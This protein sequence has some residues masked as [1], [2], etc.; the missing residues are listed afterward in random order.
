MSFASPNFTRYPPPGKSWLHVIAQLPVKE[1]DAVI[2]RLSEVEVAS[3]LRESWEFV[4][5]REQLP[6]PGLWTV[7]LLL[8]GRGFGK[9]RTGSEWIYEQHRTGAVKSQSGIIAATHNDLLRYCLRGPSGLITLT[10]D[11]PFRPR[12]YPSDLMLVWPDETVTLL[13]SSEKPDRIR[14]PN[15]EKIWGD[16]FASWAYMEECWD[17]IEFA[18]RESD[19]PRA[20]LTTTPKPR[21]LLRA[22]MQDP[23]TI[24]TGGRQTDNAENLSVRYLSRMRRRYAGTRQGRQELNAEL[25]DEA[26]GA[27]WKREWIDTTRV[28]TKPQDI[29]CTAVGVDPAATK[30]Q[31]SDETGIVVAGRRSAD[32]GAILEDLSGRFSPSDWA[33]RAVVAY[34]AWGAAAI[35][36]ERNNGGDMVKMTIDTVAGE[37]HREDPAMYPS[38]FVNVIVVWASQGKRARAEPVSARYEQGR[39]AHYGSFPIMED[40][41]CTWEPNSNEKSPDRLDAAVWALTWL[42]EGGGVLN[43]IDEDDAVG[44]RLVSAD[45]YMGG[46]LPALR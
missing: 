21:K 11:R 35:V 36:A 39:V 37:M 25:L 29:E 13:F 14:G 12:Y 19:D 45:G 4:A 32:R 23:D 42:L 27:L 6:P 1:R 46:K 18:L 30:T 38:P 7:W 41:M 16:E 22:L 34:W 2:E 15:L 10:A 3:V 9:T 33:R 5:R 43:E 20:L 44:T 26:E 28:Q 40:Q 17:N 8:A 31:N 24:V